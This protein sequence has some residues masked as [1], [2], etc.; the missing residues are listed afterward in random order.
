MQ[1][2]AM[3]V[4]PHLGALVVR[5]QPLHQPPEARRVI[6][7]DEM[8]HFVR[9]EIIQHDA[10]RQDEPPGKRQHA[11]GRA[12]TPAARLIAH[13]DPLDG[14]AEF[15]GKPPALGLEFAPGFA[16]QEIA[17]AAIEID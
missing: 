12:G 1:I 10:G 4:E 15:G 11:G 17:D 13:G 5:A 3:H 9:G 14:D 8:R 16:A 6:H 7:L 2:A